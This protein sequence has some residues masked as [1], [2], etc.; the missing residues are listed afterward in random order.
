MCVL[1]E[2]EGGEKMENERNG[3]KCTIFSSSK[4]KNIKMMKVAVLLLPSPYYILSFFASMLHFILIVTM[5]NFFTDDLASI[6]SAQ[7]N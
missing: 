4:K 7:S 5:L 1:D 3:G 6:N 2:M